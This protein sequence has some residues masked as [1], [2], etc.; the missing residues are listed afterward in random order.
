NRPDELV[1]GTSRFVVAITSHCSGLEGIGLI[2]AFTGIYLWTCR[3]ELSFP[4]A[5]VLLPAGAIS[6]WLLNSVRIAAL[7]F[8]G[9]WDQDFALK[10]FHSAAG[11]IFFN[12]VAVGLVWTS[13]QSQLF[14]KLPESKTPANPARGYL[15]PL[16]VLFASSLF[17]RMLAPQ[18]L[19]EAVA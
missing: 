6:I 1:V 10:G 18:F 14:V 8:I 5:L 4:R 11:W 12:I 13:S 16:I 2:C 7:I 19:L 15:L 17:V 9:G 3:R